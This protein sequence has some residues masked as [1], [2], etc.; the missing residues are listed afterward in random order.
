MLSFVLLTN[1]VCCVLMSLVPVLRP[2]VRTCSWRSE[3]AAGTG[4]AG[5]RKQD[6][7]DCGRTEDRLGVTVDSPAPDCPQKFNIQCSNLTLLISVKQA[8]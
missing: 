4:A 6:N 5:H 1:E 8:G 7:E 3:S 2:Y